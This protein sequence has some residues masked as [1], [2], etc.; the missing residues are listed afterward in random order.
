MLVL[1]GNGCHY[2]ATW[3]VGLV[4]YLE[5][6]GVVRFFLPECRLSGNV[7]ACFSTTQ[8]CRFPDE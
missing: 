1:D 8:S 6:A 4:G 7:S 5:T 3:Y 2:S